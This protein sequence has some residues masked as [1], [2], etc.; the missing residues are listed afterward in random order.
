MLGIHTVK[1]CKKC[2]SKYSNLCFVIPNNV[3]HLSV[4]L[5]TG[6]KYSLLMEDR[7]I[8]QSCPFM[9]N[10]LKKLSTSLKKFAINIFF[11]Q[12]KFLLDLK[13]LDIHS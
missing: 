7:E 11:S 12:L 9:E 10:L 6:P 1:K 13:S 3:I 8:N 5:K 2:V 4:K